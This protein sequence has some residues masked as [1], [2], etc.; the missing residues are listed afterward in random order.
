M[1][2]PAKNG[3]KLLTRGQGRDIINKYDIKPR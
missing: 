3:E 1:K 2:K